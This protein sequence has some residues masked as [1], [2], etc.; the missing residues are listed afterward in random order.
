MRQ[1]ELWS[2]IG[3][4]VPGVEFSVLKDG[5]VLD[6]PEPGVDGELVIR[7]PSVASALIGARGRA[8]RSGSWPTAGGAPP[9][10]VTSTTQGRIYIVGR[11]SETII[12]GG[13]NIQPVEIERASR[14][15]TSVR[16][17]V[18]VGVPD[19]RVG[20]DTSGLR[21][22]SRAR[23]RHRGRARRLGPGRGWPGSSDPRHVFFSSDPIPRA[24]GE[25]KI[26]RGDIKRLVRRWVAE[27]GTVPSN[28]TKV[29]KLRG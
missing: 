16:E 28:V 9:T 20:R 7:T 1:P 19:H 5:Q 27:P 2:S 4:P 8:R 12:T 18:V 25:A 26:A 3:R 21:P 6:R 15:T 13:T 10:S 14:R 29:V 23:R 11:A 17:A 24:S 22:R